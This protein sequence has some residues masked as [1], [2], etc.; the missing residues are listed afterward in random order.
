MPG[1]TS[2]ETDTFSECTS[3]KKLTIPSDFI[4]YVKSQ[5]LE[6]IT[7]TCVSSTKIQSSALKNN[8]TLKSVTIQEGITIINEDAFAGCNLLETV[9]L[10]NSLTI[11]GRSAFGD[12]AKLKNIVLPSTVQEI[13]FSAFHHCG[14]LTEIKIPGSVISLGDG[15]FY[16]CESLKNVIIEEGVEYIGGY[17]HILTGAFQNCN[18]STISLPTSLKYINA[19][20]FLNNPLV[21]VEFKNP[22]G[23][24]IRPDMY[25]MLSDNI[26]LDENDLANPAFA[27]N[28]LL[29]LDGGEYTSMKRG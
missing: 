10:P 18:I 7:I 14:S 8:K 24:E 6:A 13:H 17:D 9:S 21:S 20:S 1:I 25:H 12:C 4:S 23:W 27:A 2:I 5:P 19:N 26:L 16:H 11:I 29:M 3:I 15:S 28:I 22:V